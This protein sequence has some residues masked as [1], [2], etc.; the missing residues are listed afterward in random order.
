MGKQ[1]TVTLVYAVRDEEHNGPLAV[2]RFL[3]GRQ[4]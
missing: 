2:K 4:R 1:G 3:E